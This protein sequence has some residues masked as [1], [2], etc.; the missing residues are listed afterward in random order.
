M[1]GQAKQKMMG[2]ARAELI[3]FVKKT[4]SAKQFKKWDDDLKATATK[5]NPNPGTIT[6]G[7]AI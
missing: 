3:L 1:D 7:G 5:N 2:E 6:G 4:L